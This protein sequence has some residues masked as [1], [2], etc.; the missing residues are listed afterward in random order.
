MQGLEEGGEHTASDFVEAFTG[1]S[2]Y[3]LDY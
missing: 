2:H 1:S 3:I